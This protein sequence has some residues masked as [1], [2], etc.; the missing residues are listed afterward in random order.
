MYNEAEAGNVDIK[1]YYTSSYISPTPTRIF[2]VVDSLEKEDT[3]Y[4]YIWL[5][6]PYTSRA[7][8]SLTGKHN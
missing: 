1:S 7:I 2:S 3:R 6:T 4:F 5:F 8:E